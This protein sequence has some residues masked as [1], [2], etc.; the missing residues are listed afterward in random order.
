MLAAHA[1]GGTTPK[2][3][4][5]YNA[6]DRFWG[7]KEDNWDW[8]DSKNLHKAVNGLVN[9]GRGQSSGAV[10]LVSMQSLACTTR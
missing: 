8:E 5:E 1:L 3:A 7:L 4:K 2:D 9:T 6:L 10:L